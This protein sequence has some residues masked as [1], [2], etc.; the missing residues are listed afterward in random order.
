MDCGSLKIAGKLKYFISPAQK[1]F[2][3]NMI[4]DFLISLCGFWH[5]RYGLLG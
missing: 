1:G 4:V 3:L 2:A 5:K